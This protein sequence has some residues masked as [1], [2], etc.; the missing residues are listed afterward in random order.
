V[1]NE[2]EYILT[3]EAAGTQLGEIWDDMELESKLKIVEDIISVEK[4]L[5]SLSF[6][7]SVAQ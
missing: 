5:L 4:K 7:Q 2:S 1:D 6:T 3:E